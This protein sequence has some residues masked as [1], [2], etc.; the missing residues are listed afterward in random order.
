MVTY[1]KF[2]TACL[3]PSVIACCLRRQWAQRYNRNIARY[4]SPACRKGADR[5]VQAQ[6]HREN[7]HHLRAKLGEHS[8]ISIGVERGSWKDERSPAWTRTRGEDG[9]AATPSQYKKDTIMIK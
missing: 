9:D 3:C 4:N 6:M 8:L 5:L 1:L 2:T 7:R